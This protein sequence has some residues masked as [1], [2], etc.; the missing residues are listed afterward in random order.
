MSDIIGIIATVEDDEY[1]GKSFKKVTLADGTVLKVKYGREGALKA[2][3]GLLD[4][5]EGTAMKF[6]MQEYTN[7]NGVKFPFVSDIATVEGGLPEARAPAQLLPEQQKVIDEAKP[8]EPPAPPMDKKQR[9]IEY[10]RSIIEIGELYRGGFLVE[11][12]Q[13]PVDR[14]LIAKYKQFIV[15]R[16]GIKVEYKS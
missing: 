2:K 10:L 8:D 12:E 11:D 6:S 15:D 3:W 7:P 4:G 5:A 1:Q 16:Q 13:H 9:D 14:K